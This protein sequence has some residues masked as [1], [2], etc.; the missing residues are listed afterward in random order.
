MS[1]L[2]YI[3]LDFSYKFW[4]L[5]A[6]W[7]RAAPGCSGKFFFGGHVRNENLGKVTKFGYHTITGVDMPEPNVV[8]GVPPSLSRVK[9]FAKRIKTPNLMAI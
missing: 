7:A 6:G 3:F 2:V 9:G 4:R 1:Y 5:T 8:L